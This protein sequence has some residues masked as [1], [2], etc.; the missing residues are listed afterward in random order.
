MAIS[1]ASRGPLEEFELGHKAAFLR[2]HSEKA[3]NAE[4]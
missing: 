3:K 1:L 2:W 4:G